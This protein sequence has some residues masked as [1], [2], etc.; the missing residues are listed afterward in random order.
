VNGNSGPNCV[1]NIFCNTNTLLEQ[2]LLLYIIVT[3]VWSECN[4]FVCYLCTV[5]W[6]IFIVF[7]MCGNNNITFHYIIPVDCHI[8]VSVCCT[9]LVPKSQCMQQLMY[10]CSVWKA[11]V[12]LQVQLLA[13]W[14]IENLWLIVAREE[15]YFVTTRSL[16]VACISA[17]AKTSSQTW[18][19]QYMSV[20][21]VSCENQQLSECAGWRSASSVGA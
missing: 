14:V 7:F 17:E 19:S 9:L 1:Q 5:N 16:I 11:F 12:A 6:C 4:I 10:N 8:V 13:L 21:P 20:V 15:R 2:P 3:G 18:W